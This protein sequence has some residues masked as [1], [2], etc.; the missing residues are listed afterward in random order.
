MPGKKQV[1]LAFCDLAPD[2]DARDNYFTQAL[3]HAGWE[4]TF[5]NGPEEKPDF[6][7]CGTFGFDFLKY[8]CC[9]IQFSGEDSWPDLN[10]YDYARGSRRWILMGATCGCAVRQAQQL[11]SGSDQAYGTG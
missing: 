6:V 11:G 7:L 3:E 1:R 9:R 4:I 5:C 2:W 8:D 10:L